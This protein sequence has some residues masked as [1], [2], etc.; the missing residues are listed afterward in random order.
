MI[1]QDHP[2]QQQVNEVQSIGSTLVHVPEL[3]ES[4]PIMDSCVIPEESSAERLE[5]QARMA[6]PTKHAIKATPENKPNP[7][8]FVTNPRDVVRSCSECRSHL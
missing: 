7:G 6:G 4:I 2:T 8:E 1:D 5:A 3:Q